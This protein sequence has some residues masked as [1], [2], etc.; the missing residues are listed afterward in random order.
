MDR[1]AVLRRVAESER[2]VEFIPPAAEAAALTA[3]A[4]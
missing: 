3:N 4:P 1:M 2:W